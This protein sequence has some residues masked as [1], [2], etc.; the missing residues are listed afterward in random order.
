MI[1]YFAFITS[2]LPPSPALISRQDFKKIFTLNKPVCKYVNG[3]ADIKCH[4]VLE[5]NPRLSFAVCTTKNYH[6]FYFI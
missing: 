4:P 2:L 5:S 6:S 1:D 3:E